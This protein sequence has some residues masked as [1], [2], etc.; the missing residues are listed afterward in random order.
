MKGVAEFFFFN[1]ARE[2]VLNRETPNLFFFSTRS[3]RRV[4]AKTFDFFFPR[5]FLSLSL[6]L[7]L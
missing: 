3:A 1:T 2:T 5:K 4:V 7:S 6:F